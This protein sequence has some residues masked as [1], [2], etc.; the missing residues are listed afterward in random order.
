MR[1]ILLLGCLRLL[2]CNIVAQSESSLNLNS[3][4]WSHRLIFVLAPDETHP[5]LV[6]QQQALEK[7][8]DELQDRELKYWIVT[9]QSI[10]GESLDVPSTQ[11]F[12]YFKVKED[13]F[14]VFLIGKD[15]GIKMRK[16]N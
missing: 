16:E 15:G 2:S 6:Q 11:I 10:H 4:Q 5:D 8:P 3:F 7:W 9:P 1:F 12:D 13:T 14:A